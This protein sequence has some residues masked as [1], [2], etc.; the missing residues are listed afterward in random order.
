MKHYLIYVTYRMKPGCRETFVKELTDR[1]LLSAVLAEDGC[2]RYE[3]FFSQQDENSL[4]LL[5]EWES[6]EHQQIH[7][8][9]PHMAEVRALK[10]KYAV[11]ASV[12]EY[13]LVL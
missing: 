8:T 4:L 11:D 5:E 1:G 9:Q 3:Y 7:V 2:C 12:G 10:E 6:K 13:T